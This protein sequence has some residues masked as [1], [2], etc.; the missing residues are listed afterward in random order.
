MIGFRIATLPFDGSV[1][2]VAASVRDWDLDWLVILRAVSNWLR[3]NGMGQR[4]VADLATDWMHC[5]GA[6][7]SLGD[8]GYKPLPN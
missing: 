3:C 7:Q 2:E 5:W 1:A 8:F 4:L 6:L